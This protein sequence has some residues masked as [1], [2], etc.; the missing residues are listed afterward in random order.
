M[1]DI[2]DYLRLAYITADENSPDPST[3][4]GA[5][6]VCNNY[7]VH[8][9]WNHLT[10]GFNDIDLS[11]RRLKYKVME[12]AERDSIFKAANNGD[13]LNGAI[14]YCPWAACCDCA[15]AIVLS[16][17]KEV[18]CHT[19][20][21]IQTPFRWKEDIMLADKIFSASGVKYTWW[22][23]KIGDCQNLFDGKVWYP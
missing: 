12:H 10:P 14:M 4:V 17:I 18:V 3:K 7:N 9:G 19:N 23:G 21:L 1:L 8:Y 11:D 20:A 22:D 16:G 5:I 15:R 2:K 6:I 13:T